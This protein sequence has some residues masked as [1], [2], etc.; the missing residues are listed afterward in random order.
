MEK[1][2]IKLLPGI[3]LNFYRMAIVHLHQMHRIFL[4]NAT[5]KPTLIYF[6]INVD[7]FYTII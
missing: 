1:T 3:I 6:A 7:N 2:L 4:K 5:S